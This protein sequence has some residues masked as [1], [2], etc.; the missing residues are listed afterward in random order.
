M[1]LRPVQVGVL[2]AKVANLLRD[3]VAAQQLDKDT[4]AQHAGISRSQLDRMLHGNRPLTTD[5]LDILAR[6]TG[7][8]ATEVLSAAEMAT[9]DRPSDHHTYPHPSTAKRSQYGT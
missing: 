4:L 9:P 1:P 8:S 7:T 3:R 6:H 5:Q 2:G